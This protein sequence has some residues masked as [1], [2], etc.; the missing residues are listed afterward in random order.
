MVKINI[1]I[2]I[3]F[4]TFCLLGL[5]YLIWVFMLTFIGYIDSLNSINQGQR[6]LKLPS[7]IFISI[8]EGHL[9]NKEDCS[10]LQ[11]DN[12]LLL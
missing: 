5:H 4:F 2:C 3:N 10:S 9:C 8:E 7:L 1:R 11:K 12:R 6:W